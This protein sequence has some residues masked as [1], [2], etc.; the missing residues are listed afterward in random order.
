MNNIYND[1]IVYGRHVSYIEVTIMG[2][3]CLMFTIWGLVYVF[4]KDKWVKVEATIGNIDKNKINPIDK[5]IKVN[6]SYK[7]NN[8][9]Y[10]NSIDIPYNKYVV[11]NAIID[12]F[13]NSDDPTKEVELMHIKQKTIGYILLVVAFI[14]LMSA[15]YTFFIV[16]KYRM[17]AIDNVFNI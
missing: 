5:T 8:T 15:L 11:E 12:I 3:F 9:A 14:L 4:K 1:A 16:S 2:I 13:V 17:A 7:V 6:V 10:N